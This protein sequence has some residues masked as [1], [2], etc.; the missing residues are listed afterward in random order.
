MGR[1]P[2][3][4]PEIA[5]GVVVAA[6]EVTDPLELL[7][8]IALVLIGL[9]AGLVGGMLG[10]GGSIIMIPAMT[11]VLGPNQHLYQAAAMIVN[12]FVVVP[13]VY[14]HRR[15]KAIEVETALRIIPFAIV[16]VIAGVAMSEL[17]IFAG[18]GEA[19]LR[20]LFGLFLLCVAAYDL[21]RLFRRSSARLD[22]GRAEGLEHSRKSHNGT[23]L[24]SPLGKGGKRRVARCTTTENALNNPSRTIRWSTAA[25]VAVPTGLVA[26]LL[27]VGGGILAVPLQRR[28]LHIPMRIAVANSAT[29][30]IATSLVGATVKNYAYTTNHDG[31]IRAFLLAAVLIP[32]AILGSLVGSKLTHELPL[33]FVKTAFFVLLLAAAVRLTYKAWGPSTETSPGPMASRVTTAATTDQA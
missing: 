5:A 13:A 7:E 28:F 21:Y 4:R 15:A 2:I 6:R 27:G 26:G 10:V 33:R 20:G 23:P 32:T 8:L 29:I 19:N 22:P 31:S 17:H 16:A 12:F 18:K 25:A 14:Q 3:Q 11:E 30:I 24:A 1:R 9:F